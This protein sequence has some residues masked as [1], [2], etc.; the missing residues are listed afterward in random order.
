MISQ[1][2]GLDPL[3]V[4]RWRR[5][6]GLSMAKGLDDVTHLRG[7]NGIAAE[8][9][10]RFD[11][12]DPGTFE[13]WIYQ[14]ELSLM[15]CLCGLYTP[16]SLSR[17]AEHISRTE[18]PG[19]YVFVRTIA[20]GFVARHGRN[21]HSYTAGQLVAARTDMPL[22]LTMP[23][24]GDMTG[25]VIPF[26]LLGGDIGGSR[27]DGGVL[28]A[29]NLLGRA[30]SQF[31]RRLCY[32]A[33]TDRASVDTEFEEAG[34]NL[35][36]NLLGNVGHDMDRGRDIAMSVRLATRELI[37][38]NFTDPSFSADS[39]ARDLHISR[40]HLYR[41]FSGAGDSVAAMITSRR[42]DRARELLVRAGM[43]TLEEVA[44]L[45]GFS[46]VATM[47]NR[48]RGRYGLTPSEF[49]DRSRTVGGGQPAG[50]A[51]LPEPA[52]PVLD[53]LADLDDGPSVVS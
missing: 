8:R 14:R 39:I 15:H 31:I 44:R 27:W 32:T 13:A 30:T 50:L 51:G 2:H 22:T 41:Q 17:D 29:D 43:I 37:E 9:R 45:S 3:L 23:T 34:L 47:R 42:L 4:A 46:S 52:R 49:R 36:R 35:I 40:R 1:H 20:G 21:E 7:R 26:D 5:E 12:R 53:P 18:K 19:V 24:A 6:I 33:V 38:E 48:F 28:A 25:V 10:W 16:C 11:C